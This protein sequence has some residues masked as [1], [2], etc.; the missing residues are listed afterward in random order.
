[1]LY[2]NPADAKIK[3]ALKEFHIGIQEFIFSRIDKYYTDSK[4]NRDYITRFLENHVY[5][6][7]D[8]ILIGEPHVIAKINQDIKPYIDF[9]PTIKDAIEY[10]FNY[11][12]FIT[13]SKRYDG[14]SLAKALDTRTCTY[15]NRNYTTTVIKAGEKKIT[16]PQFDHFFDKGRNPLLAISFYNLIPSCSICN[17]TIK[18]K[19]I[20]DLDR[21]LHPYVDNKHSDIRFSY[22]YSKEADPKYTI[23]TVTPVNSKAR[24]TV[25]A[26]A[27]DAIY[28]SHIGE[29]EDLI[30]TKQYFSERYISILKSHLLREVVVGEQDIYRIV[31][32][33]EFDS[34]NFINR[35]FSKF[36]S[37]ILR[38]LGII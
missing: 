19:K 23:S 27:I 7:L 13:K 14:Y 10:I 34:E 31:F 1:M 15:C 3:T 20:M 37:D 18:G 36:K 2:I 17:S 4:I 9:S 29:L 32:G 28:N 25:E 38:E 30:Q 8:E 35:P 22:K 24:K 11:K 16:R 5:D 21:Y 6:K 12:K 33:T 26:F